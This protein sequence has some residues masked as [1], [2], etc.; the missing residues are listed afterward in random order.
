MLHASSACDAGIGACSLRDGPVLVAELPLAA[1]DLVL[2]IDSE[3]P[4][5]LHA[6]RA[7][8]AV[9]AGCAGY[10]QLL[11]VGDECGVE[12]LAFLVGEG[13]EG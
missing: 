1:G 2:V 6:K 4:G 5:D 7:W 3:D 9:S 11:L 13:L 12:H 10:G 8:H